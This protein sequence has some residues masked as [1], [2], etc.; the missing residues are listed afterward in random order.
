MRLQPSSLSDFTARPVIFDLCG[1]VRG[2]DI[3]DLGAGEGY[4]ARVLASQGAAKVVGVELSSEMVA[5][6]KSL[7]GV[8]DDVIEYKC[9]TVTALDFLTYLLTLRWVF[10]SI[11]TC[12]FKIYTS[13]F[14]R[15]TVF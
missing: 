11:T 13:L 12:T 8:G 1:D 15:S 2:L 14:K 6:A 7:Q 10:S 4:C 9:G 5:T 3:I